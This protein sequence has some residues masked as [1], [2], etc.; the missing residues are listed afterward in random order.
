MGR[1]SPP[2]WGDPHRQNKVPETGMLQTTGTYSLV[3]LEARSVKSGRGQGRVSLQSISRRDPSLPLPASG[4]CR[5]SLACGCTP[6]PSLSLRLHVTLV[7]S[8]GS[9][10]FFSGCAGSRLLCAGSVVAVHGLSCHEACEVLVPQPGI[11]PAS[12]ALE[13][14]FFTTEPPRKSLSVSY[15]DNLSLALEPI[16]VIQ[17]DSES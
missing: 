8:P 9:P 4:G 14:R 12:P 3:F 15:E 11:E 17:D 5:R 2:L 10:L 7:S 6:S 16:W 1:E 13:G